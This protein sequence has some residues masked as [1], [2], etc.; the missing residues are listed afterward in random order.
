MDSVA[1]LIGHYSIYWSTVIVAFAAAVGVFLFWFFYLWDEPDVVGA[2]CVVPLALGLGLVL[3]RLCHWYFRQDSYRSLQEAMT[4][5][6]VGDLALMGAFAGCFLAACLAAL[7]RRGRHFGAMLDAMSVAGAGAVSLG[8]LS[9]LCNTADRGGIVAE[10]SI[11]ASALVNPSTGA[12]EYRLAT[13]LIQALVTAAV[14]L[15][16][17]GLYFWGR[18][19]YRRANG[20]TPGCLT[21]LGSCLVLLGLAGW[22][23][24]YVQRHGNQA[25][26]AYT[27]MGSSLAGVVLLGTV[28]WVLTRR[29]EIPRSMPTIYPN[30]T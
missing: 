4:D 23:E 17:V 18:K 24:Y 1:F 14:F 2:F 29:R 22:M 13:F 3:A 11:W 12:T 9:G 8:R 16:L 21:V 30:I 28:L 10:G 7:V 6:S 25:A 15:L 5:Y 26:F 19:G 20:W 27:V